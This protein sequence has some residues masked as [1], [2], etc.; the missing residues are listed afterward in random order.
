MYSIDSRVQNLKVKYACDGSGLNTHEYK[1]LYFE[2]L[3]GYNL[4]RGR[5]KGRRINL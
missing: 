5:G 3:T 4:S 2:N 1:T